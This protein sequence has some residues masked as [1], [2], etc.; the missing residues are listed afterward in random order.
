MF[1]KYCQIGDYAGF[2]T[3]EKNGQVCPFVRRCT[4]DR[5]WKPLVSMDKCA[6][7]KEEVKVPK[8]MSRVRFELHGELYVEVGEF[9]Y[10]IKNPYDYIPEFV[11]L[12][13]VNDAW[14]IKGFEPKP[15][16]KSKS[17]GKSDGSKG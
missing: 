9:V 14:Y 11:E 15:S 16:K 1:C 6:L 2:C 13:S 5:V 8:G 12:V 17:G 10:S 7:R 4:N 3:C